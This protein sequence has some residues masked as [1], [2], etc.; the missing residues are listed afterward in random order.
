MKKQLNQSISLPSCDIRTVSGILAVTLFN[1]NNY[2]IQASARLVEIGM[3]L[4]QEQVLEC[5]ELEFEEIKNIVS[6]SNLSAIEKVTIFQV[7]ELE[8]SEESEK[9]EE[10]EDSEEKAD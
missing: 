3:K 8:E 1:V 9:T 4:Q 7:L 10:S 5:S 6:K 2:S